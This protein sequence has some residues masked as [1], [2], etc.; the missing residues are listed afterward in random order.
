MSAG[1]STAKSRTVPG[2]IQAAPLSLFT[3]APHSDPD[4]SRAAAKQIIPW[5]EPLQLRVLEALRDGPL[6]DAAIQQRTGLSGDTERPRR[7][8][9]VNRFMVEHAGYETLPTNRKAKTWRLT[10]KGRA[11]L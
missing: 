8:A 7:I 11:A 6:S 5:T 2:G 1:R 3:L 9:L 10:E 4:T